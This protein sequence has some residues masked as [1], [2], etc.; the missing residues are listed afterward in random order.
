MGVD[1]REHARTRW[2]SRWFGEA[3]LQ[4]YP[5]RDREEAERAV[6]LVLEHAHM[7]EGARVLDIACGAGRHLSALRDRG[8]R[9]VGLDL[10]ATLLRVGRRDHPDIPAVRGDMRCLP[11]DDGS[12]DLVTSFFTSFGY[13]PEMAEDRQVLEEARR[14][15]APGGRFAFDFLNAR[16][17]RALLQPRDEREME[18]RRV[19]QTR[20]L[21]ED[22]QVVEKRIEIHE[23]SGAPDVFYERVRLYSPEEL[24]VMLE[25]GGFIPLQRF[26]DYDGAP[27]EDDS[28]RVI[29][30]GRA[31]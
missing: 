12:F 27:L 1:Q 8:V 17:V 3:Y 30:L 15:L 6:G 31:R 16:R 23:G 13:F 26:G 28:P 14:V 10:S 24:E 25:R 5:H 20:R 2:Y 4:L 11:F 22:D 9:P 19:V 7:A 29:L 18:G 21:V